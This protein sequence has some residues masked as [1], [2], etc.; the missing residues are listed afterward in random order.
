MLVTGRSALG[1]PELHRRDRLEARRQEGAQR[2]G[3]ARGARGD[4]DL[5]L[6]QE[7]QGVADDVGADVVLGRVGLEPD[8]GQPAQP[9]E[10]VT[11]V[12]SSGAAYPKVATSLRT[13][14][15]CSAR[16]W[17]RRSLRGTRVGSPPVPRCD[18]H[19]V[20]GVDPAAPA[21]PGDEARVAGA[22]RSRPA[23]S[24]SRVPSETSSSTAR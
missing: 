5:A 20:E 2:S 22:R 17:L 11:S 23:P 13:D 18:E 8:L 19:D 4:D 24:E 15:A 12:W 1:A 7:R 14:V 3:V 10:R 6:G 21:R 16:G 9:V